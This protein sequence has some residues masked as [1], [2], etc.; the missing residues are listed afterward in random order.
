MSNFLN[1]ALDNMQGKPADEEVI[2]QT[3]EVVEEQVEEVVEEVAVKETIQEQVEVVEEQVE[4]T[5]TKKEIDY[6]SWLE[7]NES[8]IK[9]YL[10]EK[11][12]DYTSLDKVE[13]VRLKLKNDNPELDDDEIAE[14]MQDKYGL[15]LQKKEIN[16]DEMDAEDIEEAEAYNKQIDKLISKGNRE[17]KKDAVVASKFF[18]DRKSTFELPKFEVDAEQAT[19]NQGEVFDP[20]KYEESLVK[21]QQEYKEQTWIPQLKTI[22]DPLESVQDRVEF[23]DNGNKV[24]LDI[25]YKLSKAEKEEIFTH[26]TDYVAHPSDAKYL[27]DKGNVDTE[28]FSADKATELIYKKILKTACKEAYVLG[29]KEFVKNDLV[30]FDDSGNQ[31]GSG[32]NETERFDSGFFKAASANQKRNSL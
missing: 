11:S 12:T 32:G 5:P 1:N 6:K 17:L 24:V 20:V 16:R 9:T 10:N 29:R 19:P 3:E 26:L 31:R 21:Q 13:V 18:E 28:R 22:I 27:D 30:N 4:V 8:T 23:E 25:D 15:G 14:E 7:E 2:E